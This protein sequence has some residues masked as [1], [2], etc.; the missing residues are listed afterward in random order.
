[1]FYIIIH[2]VAYEPSSSEIVLISEKGKAEKYFNEKVSELKNAYNFQ[3]PSEYV[4][5][6]NYKEA[7]FVE[8]NFGETVYL[9]ELKINDVVNLYGRT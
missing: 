7:F 2:E 3:A 8:D 9:K 4:D 6:C 5:D 1:M